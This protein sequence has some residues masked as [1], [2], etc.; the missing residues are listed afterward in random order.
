VMLS[1]S[2]ESQLEWLDTLLAHPACTPEVLATAA[3]SIIEGSASSSVPVPALAASWCAE[4]TVLV[5]S[6]AAAEDDLC[7]ASTMLVPSLARAE[8][9]TQP[10]SLSELEDAN[11]RHGILLMLVL[12]YSYVMDRAAINVLMLA[13]YIF[14]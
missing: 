14:W 3:V 12:T 8:D 5:P 6:L 1:Q 9:D 7:V 13:N 11:V 2:E 4:S 10:A